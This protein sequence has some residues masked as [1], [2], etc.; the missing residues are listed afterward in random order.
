MKPINLGSALNFGLHCTWCFRPRYSSS[1]P[2]T[3]ASCTNCCKR[4]ASYPFLVAERAGARTTSAKRPFARTFS[5]NAP[6]V[7]VPD[8]PLQEDNAAGFCVLRA[9]RLTACWGKATCK[10]KCAVL[11]VIAPSRVKLLAKILPLCCARD[12]SPFMH[13]RIPI[14]P[15][16]QLIWLMHRL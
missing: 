14:L 13:S 9:Y 7:H 2:V 3:S 10:D 8:A 6:V 4:S 1:L 16:G 12:R 5:S 11:F 15:L